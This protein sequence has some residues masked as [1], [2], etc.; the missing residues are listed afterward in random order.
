M[1]MYA[2]GVSTVL[3]QDTFRVVCS[4][5]ASNA[6]NPSQKM[7]I[8]IDFFDQRSGTARKYTL[9]S[10]YQ[11]KLWQGTITGSGGNYKGTVVLKNGSRR[12]FS[13]T[14]DLANGAQGY[15]MSLDGKLSE[16]PGN[17]PPFTASASLPCV[18]L[19]P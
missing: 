4:G 12:L 14:F 1:T 3:A 13:G 5:F 17:S 2:F 19:T 15:T 11:L 9:S 10:I 8:S 18:N 16:D 6:D 7:G